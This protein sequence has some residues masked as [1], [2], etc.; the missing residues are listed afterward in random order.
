MSAAGGFRQ[1]EGVTLNIYV[2]NLSFDTAD[3]DLLNVFSPY[4][5]VQSARVA[6]APHTQRSRG[7]GFVEM[8][9]SGEANAAIKCPE[10]QGIFRARSYGKRV[11]SPI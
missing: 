8:P 1:A 2:G 9:D 6:V 3:A 7:V 5:K 10:W 4:G 11:T